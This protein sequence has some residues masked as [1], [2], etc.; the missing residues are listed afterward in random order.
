[1]IDK[2]KIG[3]DISRYI[4]KS[5]GVGIYAANLVKFL[6][7]IDTDNEYLGYPFF[8]DCFPEGWNK[9]ENAGIF[10]D[11]YSSPN[12]YTNFKI[13]N[14]GLNTSALKKKWAK[15][16]IEDKENLLGNADVIHST[17]YIV[18]ELLNAKLVVTIHDLSFLLYPDMHTEENIRLL[19]QNLI[20]INS[21]PD[22]II[23]DSNQTK[24][25]LI[26]FFH[27]PEEKIKVIYL[28]VDHIFSDP[29]SEENKEKILNNYSLGGLNYI[30]CVSSI[31]PRKNFERIIKVFS[32]IVKKEK[33]NDLYLVCAGG[34]GW[35]NEAIHNL[36]KNKGLEE[37]V[38]FLGYVEERDLPAIYNRAKF[39]MY[40]SIYEGFGL[41]VL[42]AMSSKVA[43]LT[44]NVSSL[45][46]VAGDAAV[47][48]D[49]FNKKEIYKASI[50]LLENEKLIKELKIKGF[51]RANLFS[52][53]NTAFQTLEVYQGVFKK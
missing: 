48:V 8:Y 21:R 50:S 52:W 40:P 10:S 23:C 17:A 16:S 14:I 45:P 2:M 19:M 47:M 38:K 37:K 12:I 31:E 51:E 43:V 7:K 53:E 49:P 3:I 18:P 42:E 35:K 25:D 29:V 22:K 6:L 46:E 44:S 9:E 28:G 11:Y 39:F 30:L 33:Y 1:M 5:G 41:P 24:K 20:Y 27:V 34:S 15:S 13:N 36:V 4:D 26:R 32:E